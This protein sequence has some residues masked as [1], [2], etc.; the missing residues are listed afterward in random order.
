MSY[1]I[2]LNSLRKG[3]IIVATLKS[4]LKEQLRKEKDLAVDYYRT[5]PANLLAEKWLDSIERIIKV[6]EDRKRY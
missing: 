6:C 5:D 1:I 2:N 4:K 3:E